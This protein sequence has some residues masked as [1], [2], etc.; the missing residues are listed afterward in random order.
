MG[1]TL[2]NKH[3]S[4]DLGSG[5]FYN[6][7]KNI[8][9]LLSKEFQELYINWTSGKMTN[10]EGNKQLLSL[11]NRKIL[12]DEDDVILNFLFASDVDGKLAVKDSRSLYNL[13]KDYDDNILYGYAGRPDCFRFKDFKILLKDSVDHRLVITWD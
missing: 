8:A 10:D 2:R 12:K 6:L 9:G 1:I 13:V 11:Y 3:M 7:R 5:G 4:F